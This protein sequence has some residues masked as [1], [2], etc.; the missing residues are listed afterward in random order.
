MKTLN[1]DAELISNIINSYNKYK[2]VIRFLSLGKNFSIAIPGNWNLAKLNK[3]IKVNFKED[4]KSND[5]NYIYLGK[6]ISD[7]NLLI[8]TIF[9]YIIT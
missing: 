2:V 3:F 8:E 7:E 1:K 6:G 5:F 4:I 9:V